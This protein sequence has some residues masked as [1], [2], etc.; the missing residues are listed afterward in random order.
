M[1]LCLSFWLPGKLRSFF[2]FLKQKT[3]KEMQRGLGGSE[4][5]IRDRPEYYSKKKK[6]KKKK[7]ILS[8]TPPFKKHFCAAANPLQKKKKRTTKKKKKEDR[9][10][11]NIQITESNR[12]VDRT[13][14]S[15]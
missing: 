14:N 5:G 1:F 8:R 7:L 3:A 11:Q 15:M 4:M 10:Q 6:K 9:K 2:F 12:D 13:A